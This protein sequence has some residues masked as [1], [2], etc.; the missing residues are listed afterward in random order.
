MNGRILTLLSEGRSRRS[1]LRVLA[2]TRSELVQA[3]SSDELCGSLGGRS[4]DL[5]VLD[6]EA[7]GQE[8]PELLSEL[9]LRC[10]PQTRIMVLAPA[11]SDLDL[12]LLLGSSRLNHLLAKSDPLASRE[13]LVS[14]E[15]CLR[16]DIFG[17]EKYLSWGI[18]PEGMLVH[19]S[20]DR[21]RIIERLGQYLLD[22]QLGQRMR[23]LAS[24]VADEL[25]MNAV[26]NAPVDVHGRRLFSDVSR[27]ERVHLDAGHEALF[28][29]AC[30]GKLLA[31]SIRDPFGS[32]ETSGLFANISRCLRRDRDQISGKAGGA[33]MGLFYIFSSVNHLVVNLAPGRA[34]EMIGL[35]D[36][37]GSYRSLV[38][39]P[40]SLNV[41]FAQD[42]RETPSRPR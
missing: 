4:F 34:T 19:G 28:R 15:K 42:R 32:L 12:A 21:E 33:G 23:D 8:P 36:V 20:M 14:C 26:Y 7:C 9:S 10:P 3:G 25:L 17:M 40:K 1:I 24:S 29:Y 37:S 27:T 35:L 22:L 30:D 16:G 41:F 13:M 18:E 39:Q 31:L 5:V 2:A 11:L 6:H 38:A